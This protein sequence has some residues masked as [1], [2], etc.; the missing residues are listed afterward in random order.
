MPDGKTALLAVPEVCK[1]KIII[2]YHTNL[3]AGQQGVIKT[4][5]TINDKF[6]TPGLMHYLRSFIKGCH[7]CQLL[8]VDKLPTRQLQPR[9]YLNYRPLSRL[10]MDLKVMPRSQ[11][12][13]KLIL[14]V[15]DEVTNYLITVPIYHTKSEEV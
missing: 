4:Y 15:I 5:L 8:K 2:L 1:D 6:F 3:F 7:T 12:G 14:C 9:I 10:S 11:K 13:D